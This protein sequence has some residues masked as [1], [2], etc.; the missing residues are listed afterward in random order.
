MY[1]GRDGTTVIMT[2]YVY[3]IV[4]ELTVTVD[5]AALVVSKSPIKS[6]DCRDSAQTI[7][8]NCLG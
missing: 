7:S 1:K 4:C 5:E 8:Q 3:R 2:K 6:Y